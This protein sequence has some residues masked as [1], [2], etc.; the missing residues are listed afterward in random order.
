M[1]GVECATPCTFTVI[2][3]IIMRKCIHS[4]A[5]TFPLLYINLYEL[6]T[7]IG[8]FMTLVLTNKEANRTEEEPNCVWI[9]LMLRG[10]R[11]TTQTSLIALNLSYLELTKLRD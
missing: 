7:N 6:S 3:G 1:R 2:F 5:V 4:C 10:R 8:P 11:L 9:Q